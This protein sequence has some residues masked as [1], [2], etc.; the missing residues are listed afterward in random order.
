MK[1]GIVLCV[2]LLC[3]L[4]SAP[5]RA[6]VDE[7]YKVGWED[8]F[9]YIESSFSNGVIVDTAFNLLPTR[10]VPFLSQARLILA[11]AGN[12]L[13]IR[14]QPLGIDASKYPFASVDGIQLMRV[15][16]ALERARYGKLSA[17]V[18]GEL[19]AYSLCPWQIPQ[20]LDEVKTAIYKRRGWVKT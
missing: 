12:N 15:V 5:A 4:V 7:K 14:L 17:V 11:R 18:Q 16:Y 20:C 13:K 8:S 1:C 6:A 10:Y 2:L 9:Q 3:G 19:L